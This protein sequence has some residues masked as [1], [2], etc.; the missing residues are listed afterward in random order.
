MDNPTL[1]GDSIIY[2][3][4]GETAKLFATYNLNDRSI[5]DAL[6]FPNYRPD[7]PTTNHSELYSK[8]FRYSPLQE[9]MVLAFRLF[10][11]VRIY[12]LENSE[13]LELR[14]ESKY[15][16]EK[17]E[18]EGQFINTS[19]LFNYYSAIDITDKGIYAS[20]DEFRR[21]WDNDGTFEVLRGTDNRELHSYDWQGNPRSKLVFPRPAVRYT[22]TPDDSKLFYLKPEVEDYLYFHKIN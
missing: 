7:I 16:Q 17:I 9:K 22:T 14:Y 4:P 2:G 20:Y 12:N 8:V 11:V 3:K 13:Y 19:P 18:Y 1:I 10:P 5:S 15:D 6:D 21:I